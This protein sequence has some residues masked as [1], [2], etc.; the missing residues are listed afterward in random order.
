MSI[1]KLRP[2]F[3]LLLFA[4]L[5][6]PLAAQEGEGDEDEDD[7]GNLPIESDWSV[8]NA[9]LYSRGD[10]AFTITAGALFPLFFLGESGLVGNKVKIGG[11]FNLAYNWFYNAHVF[12]GGEAGFMFAPTWGKN[13]LFMVPF[14]LRAGYQFLVWR[15]EFPVSL[16]IGAAPQKKQS[17]EYFGF[18]AK[19]QA[20]VFWRFLPAWSFGLTTSWWWVPQWTDHPVYGNFTELS[21]TARYH[22]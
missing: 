2:L 3:V 1:A 22:F 18:F 13:M 17:E 11:T 14:G 16:M 20:S 9:D 6:L 5:L 12:F 10:K 7:E 19:A 15:F 4:G 21:L 8:I